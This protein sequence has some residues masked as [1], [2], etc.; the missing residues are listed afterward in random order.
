MT[1][2]YKAAQSFTKVKLLRIKTIVAFGRNKK[3]HAP[4]FII[5][6]RKQIKMALNGSNAVGGTWAQ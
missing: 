1:L 3:D 6:T 2:E 5:D 4:I